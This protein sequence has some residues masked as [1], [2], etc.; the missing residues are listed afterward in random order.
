MRVVCYSGQTY[1]ERPVRFD[2]HGR[3]REVTEIMQ[4]WQEPGKRCFRVLT[5]DGELFNLCYKEAQ[6]KWCLI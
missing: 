5:G 3:W 6:D 2:W 1:A 4:A